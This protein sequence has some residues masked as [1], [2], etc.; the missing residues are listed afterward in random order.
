MSTQP[1]FDIG[2]LCR[3]DS[4][5]PRY[6][7]YPTAPQFRE[8]FGEEQL[9]RWAWRSNVQVSPRPI[10]LYVHVPYCF[11]PCFYC[12]CNRTIS[13]DPARGEHYVERLLQEPAGFAHTLDT[14]VGA[15]PERVAVYGYAHLPALFKAQR[16]I[17]S[18]DL[19]GAEERL[20][21]LQLA[22][23]R[24]GAAGYRH[25][26]M[27]HFALPEDDLARAQ[28]DSRL[29]RNFMGYT[30]HAGCDLI[31]LGP[32]AISHIGSS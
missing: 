15:R 5:G 29:H 32:S 13:R 21:L 27:D 6:T 25:I 2:V 12:G 1:V 14:V 30:T 23:E 24:L 28:E 26:G 7:S 4:P 8:D 18:A 16:Q 10:S 9:R 3:Y 19:P 11:S 31:G 22:V 20:T 17:A